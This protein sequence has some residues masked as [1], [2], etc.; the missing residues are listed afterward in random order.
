VT[1][2]PISCELQGFG[3][4]SPDAR[5]LPLESFMKICK[6]ETFLLHVPV[7]GNLIAD[8]IHQVSHWGVPGVILHTDARLRGY[9]YTGTHAHLPTDRLIT[10]AIE[11]TYGPLL[12]GEEPDDILRLWQKLNR[13]PP[14]QWVGR[15]GILKLAYAAI[16]VALWDLKAKAAGLPLWRLLGGAHDQRIE[17]YNTDCGWLDIPKPELVDGCRRLVE[18]EGWRGLKIK[19]GNPEPLCDLDRLAAVRTAVGPNVR[20]AVDVNGAWD[21]PRAIQYGR[22]LAD[23]DIM[24]LE[25]PLWY[26]DCQGHA[27]LAKAIETPIAVGEQLYS[28]DGFRQ[29]I[30][31]EATHYVQPD[32]VRLGGV[33]EW[34]QVAD[35][36]LSHRLPVA[37]HAGDM[38]QISLQLALAHPACVVLEYIPWL[39][40]CF[41]EP[42]IVKEGY[43]LAP[44]MPGAGTTLRLDAQNRFGVRLG[45]H[46]APSESA[47]T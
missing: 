19:I 3:G 8:S 10:D 15:A 47:N 39:R 36:A 40:D 41:E 7:T 34:W 33:T 9:G 44:Q 17:A 31:A 6:I 24:W 13:F 46:C 28:L 18:E 11:Y 29:F 27:Q 26:D 4:A 5:H 22:H 23:Y 30:A 20:I 25:E 45:R 21:L 42:V 16:D 35:L 38:V 32:A 2:Q 12:A 43:A 1:Q 14:A 37:T